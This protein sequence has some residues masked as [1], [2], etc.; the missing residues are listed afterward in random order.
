V[1]QEKDD[2]QANFAEDRAQIQKEKEQLL[3]NQI[4]VKEAVTRALCFVMGL[5]HM[6]EH[7]VESQVGKLA[8]SIQQLQ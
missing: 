3:A 8:K 5:E 1:Q 7:P 2:L 4:E 6:E